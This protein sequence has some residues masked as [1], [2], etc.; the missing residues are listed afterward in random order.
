[1]VVGGRGVASTRRRC[2]KIV[3]VPGPTGAAQGPAATPPPPADAKKK[4]SLK[5]KKN[6]PYMF[7]NPDTYCCMRVQQVILCT[8]AYVL[9]K[10]W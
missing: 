3:P 5:F 7:A 2:T 8:Y 1:M 9:Y 4:G 6:L 10:E